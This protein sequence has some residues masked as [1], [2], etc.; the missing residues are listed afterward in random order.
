[1]K[2]TVTVDG[3]TVHTDD[4][5]AAHMFLSVLKAMPNRL[6]EREADELAKKLRVGTRKH[7]K[8]LHQKECPRCH[9]T[10]KGQMGLGIHYA[11]THKNK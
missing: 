2:Y 1:M 6:S 11:R 3:M 10:F 7:K 8:H 4:V 5:M 9:R